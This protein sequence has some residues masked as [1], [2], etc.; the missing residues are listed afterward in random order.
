MRKSEKRKGKINMWIII[1]IIVLII[2]GALFGGILADAPGR[3]EVA[4]LNISEVRFKNLRDG[5]FIGEYK[6][7]KAHLRDAKVEVIISGGEIKEIN[8]LKGAIDKNGKPMELKNGL[9]IEDLYNNAI[10]SQS[11]QVDVISGATLTSKAH[12]K[13]LENALKQ[14]QPER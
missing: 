5:T 7:T 9:S 3:R 14:A 13:A 8:I 1:V 11:L 12:L 2:G 10:Q 6:G 4:E